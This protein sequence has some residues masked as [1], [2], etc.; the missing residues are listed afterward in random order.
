MR[1]ENNKIIL[2]DFIK[3]DIEDVIRWE[4]IETE[5]QLWDAP[6]E[7]NDFNSG[8]YRKRMMN[9]LNKKRENTSMRYRF[10]ICIKDE[11]ET[12]IGWCNIY[13]IDS[14][15]NYTKNLG[16][17]TIGIDIPKV[18]AR[19]KGYATAAW[20]LLI[21][22][23]IS[24]GIKDIYTQTWSGNLRVIGLATKIGF[25][26]CDCIVNKRIVRGD[27]YD[28]LTFKLNLDTFNKVEIQ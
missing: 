17:Y 9:L 6:W 5:W 12:H 15:F 27:L 16:N 11:L 22:Y 25:E 14:K 26:E 19:Q 18:N 8:E 20:K 7:D 2:R 23:L 13:K 10:E 21:D 4:T 28:G 24:K 3:E 1:L